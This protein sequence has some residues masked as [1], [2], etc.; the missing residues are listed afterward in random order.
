MILQFIKWVGKSF[1][2][3]PGGPSSRKLSAF[4]CLMVAGYTTYANTT[5]A[6]ATTMVAIWLAAAL[7]CFRIISMEQI[8]KLKHGNNGTTT[9]DGTGSGNAI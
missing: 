1:T 7:L 9:Q 4:L 3:E 6:N 8:T 2:A 5:A